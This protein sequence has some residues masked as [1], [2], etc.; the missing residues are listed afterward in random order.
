[1]TTPIRSTLQTEPAKPERVAPDQRPTEPIRIPAVALAPPLAA[2]ILASPSLPEWAT[3]QL[4]DPH[5]SAWG[6][7]AHVTPQALIAALT[8][9]VGAEA[10]HE[11][12]EELCG[13]L[14]G[15][16]AVRAHFETAAVLGDAQRRLGPKDPRQANLE[17]VR[18]RVLGT[19]GAK[20]VESAAAL[21]GALHRIRNAYHP[22]PGSLLD[23]AFHCLETGRQTGDLKGLA[24]RASLGAVAEHGLGILGA[25]TGPLME[26]AH[27]ANRS[28]YDDAFSTVE[29]L[30]GDE[31]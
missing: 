25:L 15:S 30:E 17:A 29:E 22:A 31:P 8:P 2:S 24:W 28:D 27:E 19:A 26:V 20:A 18:K 21:P 12:T 9:K 6:M 11:L 16:I 14:A 13:V 5:S 23:G 3:T 4:A 1:M 10:A 7:L